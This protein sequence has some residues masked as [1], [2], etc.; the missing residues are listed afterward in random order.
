VCVYGLVEAIDTFVVHRFYLT[1]ILHNLWKQRTIWRVS[2]QFQLPR[3]LIQQLLTSAASFAACISHFCQVERFSV[4]TVFKFSLTESF[5][6]FL[7]KKTRFR[8]G[9]GCLDECVIN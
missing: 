5:G 2:A 3:G 9:F 6:R 8:F 7:A 1:L 4:V